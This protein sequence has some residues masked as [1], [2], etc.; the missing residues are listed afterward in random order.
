MIYRI[1]H[2]IDHI[3]D[4]ERDATLIQFPNSN[5]VA[6]SNP[7]LD[8]ST[9]IPQPVEFIGNL[10]VLAKTDYPYIRPLAKVAG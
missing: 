3:V 6:F 7:T 5:D 10:R 2:N 9:L 8:R 4:Q 1:S